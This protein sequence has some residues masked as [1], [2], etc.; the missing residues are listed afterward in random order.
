MKLCLVKISC[1]FL[2]MIAIDIKYSC[3]SNALAIA[4]TFGGRKL[5]F[6]DKKAS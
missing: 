3:K 5:P 6:F 4:V 2:K 1:L